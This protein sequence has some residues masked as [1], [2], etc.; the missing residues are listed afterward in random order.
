MHLPCAE[1]TICLFHHV[2]STCPL[3]PAGPCSPLLQGT[4][5]V[6]LPADPFL[7]TVASGPTLR[8]IVAA[9]NFAIKT[10]CQ[11]LHLFTD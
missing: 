11:S 5:F 8:G 6:L 2:V 7:P 9:A 3:L 4:G 10:L 1:P